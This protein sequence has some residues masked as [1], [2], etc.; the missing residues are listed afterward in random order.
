MITE[1]Q[2]RAKA[3]YRREK[4]KKLVVEL[5][6]TENILSQHLEALTEPKATY[7]KRLIREDIERQKPT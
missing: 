2:K 7:I 6:P 4:S 1:A 5:F 3:K